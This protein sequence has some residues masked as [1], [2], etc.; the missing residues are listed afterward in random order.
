MTFKLESRDAVN[1]LTETLLLDDGRIKTVDNVTLLDNDGNPLTIEVGC[2]H[3]WLLWVTNRLD[4][5]YQHPLLVAVELFDLD[6]PVT[7]CDAFYKVYL[8]LDDTTSTLTL[9]IQPTQN[10]EVMVRQLECLSRFEK[11]YI[12]Q[13]MN[14]WLYRQ[15]IHEEWKTPRTDV[16]W[17]YLQDVNG[18]ID[19]NALD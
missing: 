11:G 9:R 7:D 19:Y 16:S 13:A 5:T 14:N 10:D 6:I 4:F 18:V 12:T 2:L 8:H 1:R 15:K 17:N 3:R